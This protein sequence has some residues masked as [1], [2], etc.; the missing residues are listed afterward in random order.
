M[1]RRVSRAAVLIVGALVI[2]A[3]VAYA[4]IPSADGTING[5]YDKK[6]GALRVIDS[7][8]AATCTKAETAVS[9]NMRGLAGDQG[10]SGPKGDTGLKGDPGVQGG[11]GPK[12]D[13]G[14]Q[15]AS[16]PK[17]D[18]GVQGASGPKGDPG[19]KGDPG[20]PGATGPAGPA[21]TNCDL[22]RRIKAA[23]SS[24]EIDPDCVA[25]EVAIDQAPTQSDPT[26]SLEISFVATFSG[27]IDE[28]SFT[29][30]DV[31]LGGTAGATTAV[32]TSAG[33]N[34]F[35]IS[36]SGMAQNGTVTASIPADAV[37][38]LNGNPNQA[39][40]STDNTV[41]LARAAKAQG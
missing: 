36:V 39:S 33:V 18:P 34:S 35:T 15:G 41:T 1:M 40:T 4:T 11:S 21:G 7:A 20:E 6:S 2:A 32:I 27:P 9:W 8:T 12:G 28:T 24:F 23:L 16:G 13:T 17:G 14:V 25:L 29:S 3:G 26:A 19:A 22:E 31:Q 37:V 10:P 30:S 5:C 38:D